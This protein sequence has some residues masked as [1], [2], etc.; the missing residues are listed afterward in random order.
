MSV[1]EKMCLWVGK[2]VIYLVGFFSCFYMADLLCTSLKPYFNQ[3]FDWF[4][5][6]YAICIIAIFVVVVVVGGIVWIFSDKSKPEDDYLSIYY[7][8]EADK[9]SMSSS[10]G[11]KAK[12][13][14]KSKGE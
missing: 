12:R 9:K 8:T 2:I 3:M 14:T 11:R 1:F 10:T 6:N 13:A 7:L 4:M 5:K